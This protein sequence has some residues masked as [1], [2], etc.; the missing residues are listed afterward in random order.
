MNRIEKIKY[1][2]FSKLPNILEVPFLLEIQL[3]SFKEFLQ[4]KVDPNK[5]VIKGLEE[6]LREIFPI[7]DYNKRMIMEYK[8]YEIN[9]PVY[10]EFECLE[11]GRTYA[12]TINIRVRL[13]VKKEDGKISRIIEENVF[14]GELPYMTERGTFVVNGSERAI[15]NQFQRSPGIFFD[16]EEEPKITYIGKIIPMYGSWLQFEIDNN[17]ILYLRIDKRKKFP[18]TLFLKVLNYPKN[19]D[20]VKLFYKPKTVSI[21]KEELL[22]KYLYDDLIDDETGEILFPA[23][24]R[25]NTAI[26][27]KIMETGKKEIK[28]IEEDSDFSAII[29]NTLEKE[30][31]L[32]FQEA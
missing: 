19:N 28:I 11:R 7:E 25:I 18:A 31:Y 21:K 27:D 32:T 2:S 29:L 14:L 26:Y 9:E 22:N 3:N 5:R 15:V 20:I 30:N 13:I 6:V 12:V 8:D 1:K 4:E 16:I 17:D 24:K 10:D 23:G